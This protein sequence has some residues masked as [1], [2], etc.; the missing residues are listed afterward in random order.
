MS[1]FQGVEGTGSSWAVQ[2]Q[3]IQEIFS[4][5]AVG[6]V[7]VRIHAPGLPFLP[8]SIL[9]LCNCIYSTVGKNGVLGMYV[10]MGEEG[11]MGAG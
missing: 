5:G 7:G 3:P 4:A 2:G 8:K 11:I 10:M 1:G 9:L 6:R